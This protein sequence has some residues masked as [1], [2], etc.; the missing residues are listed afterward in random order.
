M[1]EKLSKLTW[2]E[3]YYFTLAFQYAKDDFFTV[4]GGEKTFHASYYFH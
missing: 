1:E 4:D 2:K 3:I